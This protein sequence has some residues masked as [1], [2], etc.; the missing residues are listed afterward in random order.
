MAHVTT[1]P[2]NVPVTTQDEHLRSQ[3]R[4]RAVMSGAGGLAESVA[5]VGVVV[6]SILALAGVLPVTLL[7][8]SCIGAGAALVFEG[9]AVTS[10][11]SALLAAR[12]P[13][14]TAELEG[15]LAAEVLAG[16][17]GIVLG[18]LALIG[19]G[20][21][22]LPIVAAIIY[23]GGLLLGSGMRSRLNALHT[24]GRSSSY[25][26]IT[27]STGSS[28]AAM[29]EN[30]VFVS[31]GGEMLVGIGVLALG[32]LALLGIDSLVLALIAYLALGASL[33]LSGTALGAKLLGVRRS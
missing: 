21:L 16:A 13:M 11:V 30:V 9:A 4:S 1:H 8:I 6:L 18:I 24:E 23:G 19:L 33:L 14:G 25:E 17:A 7:A 10:R 26:G 3:R 29:M 15:G 2:I 12:L 28:T 32:I 5:A 31:T 27:T 22:V 20:P